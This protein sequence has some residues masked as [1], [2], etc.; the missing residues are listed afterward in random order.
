MKSRVLLMAA[1]FAGGF[2]LATSVAR[3]RPWRPAAETP[4]YSAPSVVRGAGLSGDEINNI[5]V[6]KKAHDAAVF[7]TSTV[8]QRDWF[9]GSYPVRG[10]GSGFLIDDKGHILTNNHV[11]SGRAPR[12]EVSLADGKKYAAQLLDRDSSNDLA[13]IKINPTR[14]VKTWPK[15]LT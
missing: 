8:L 5:D 3:W 10:T 12:I 1:V 2:I 9:F 14:P 15:A 11:V 13:L 6:Y 4:G 7:I